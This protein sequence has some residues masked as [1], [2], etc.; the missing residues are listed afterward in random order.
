MVKLTWVSI[1]V[2]EIQFI[3]LNMELNHGSKAALVARLLL[4]ETKAANV[5]F[6]SHGLE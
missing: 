3:I 5:L 6:G 4:V 1:F 2:V